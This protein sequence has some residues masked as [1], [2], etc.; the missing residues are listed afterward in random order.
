MQEKF[1]NHTDQSSFFY[2]TFLS[3]KSQPPN[4]EKNTQTKSVLATCCDLY[5]FGLKNPSYQ[6]LST[7][8][9]KS[10]FMWMNNGLP[11][12]R[13]SLELGFDVK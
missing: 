2:R 10:H 4:S 3:F 11:F 6:M 12:N 5:F 8:F 13:A 1:N 9:T 7:G